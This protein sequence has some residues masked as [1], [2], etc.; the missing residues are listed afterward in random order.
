MASNFDF[1]RN[2]ERKTYGTSVVFAHEDRAYNGTLRNLSLG[3]AFI[4]TRDVN[5]VAQGDYI[6]VTI[7]YPS[8][9]KSIKKRG[10]IKWRNDDGFA[11]QFL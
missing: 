1:K 11:I 3:G 7:P 9:K 4:E 8:G 5:H 2:H 10:L 6:H